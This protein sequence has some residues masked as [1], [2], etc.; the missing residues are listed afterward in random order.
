[1]IYTVTLNPSLDY[2]MHL[3][4]L[5]VS[6][7]NR[8]KKE[9]V[10]P[11]GKGINVSIVLNNLRIPNKALGFIAGFT[12]NEIDRIMKQLGTSTDF[13]MLDQGISR[14]NIKLEA[15]KETEIN[16]M[17]PR[18]TPADV[19][20]LYAKLD[21]I[22]DGDFLVLAGS[23]PNS[24]LDSIYQDIMKELSHKNINIVVDATKNLLLNVLKYKPFLI[25]PNH[26]ELAQMF[27]V[28]LHS[29]EEI[30]TYARK[31]QEMGAQNVLISMGGDG[32]ILI[33]SEGEVVKITVPKGT[34]VNTV[35]SGDSMVAGF[36]AG[37]LKSKDLKQALKFATAT[38]SA[39]AFSTWLATKDTIDDLLS[40]L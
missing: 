19:R 2:V 18:I 25:K 1:M 10:Y 5:E 24:V 35:G 7:V 30:V 34:V 11:G 8:S 4:N 23:I 36:I 17:G 20:E 27:N 16:G 21:E 37:Y 26:I 29:D 9:E 15:G 33:T 38:G 39:T 14:V 6:G 40:Q 12:G 13:I 22:Q 32:S 31:L 3:D 28:T